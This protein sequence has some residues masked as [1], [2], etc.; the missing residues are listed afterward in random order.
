MAREVI[1]LYHESLVAQ[2]FILGVNNVN[3]LY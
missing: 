2:S 1:E 3:G